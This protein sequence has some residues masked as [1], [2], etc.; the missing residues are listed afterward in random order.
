MAANA[1][2]S[3]GEAAVVH[4]VRSQR[5]R[6]A[7]GPQIDVGAGGRDPKQN[8]EKSLNMLYTSEAFRQ[9]TLAAPTRRKRGFAHGFKSKA[10]LPAIRRKS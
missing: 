3:N 8:I 4:R 9:R 5:P 1:P 7:V 10:M 6:P 2:K